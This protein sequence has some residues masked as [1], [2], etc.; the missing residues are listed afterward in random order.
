[1][2]QCKFCDQEIPTGASQCPKCGAA[3]GTQ[4]DASGLPADFEEQIAAMLRQSGII[5]AIKLYREF[6]HVGLA[7][8]KA[9]VEAIQH[10]LP[11]VPSGLPGDFEEQLRGLVQRGE[12]IQAIVL[13]RERTGAGLADAKSAVEAIGAGA[14]FSAAP[15]GAAVSGDLQQELMALMQKGEKIMAIKRYREATGVGLKEAKDA[16]EA[17]PIVARDALPKQ[18]GC[19]GLV[20]AGVLLAALAG[21][22]LAGY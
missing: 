16:V 2:P 3:A 11:P 19:L 12:K 5:Q 15:A 17:L 18:G 4:D 8:A 7:E 9:A 6:T 20:L 13:Y 14:P 22:L 1:M 10:R 21:K